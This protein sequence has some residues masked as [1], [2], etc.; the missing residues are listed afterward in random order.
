[1]VAQTAA[2]RNGR[3]M[4][5][6]AAICATMRITAKVLRVRSRFRCSEIASVRAGS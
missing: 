4:Q 5:N 2:G 3:K 1:M 6:E